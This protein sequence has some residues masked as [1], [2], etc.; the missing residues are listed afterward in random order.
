MKARIKIAALCVAV[1][2]A[3]GCVPGCHSEEEADHPRTATVQNGPSE[4]P[5]APASS[6][7]A[8]SADIQTLQN[9]AKK[10]QQTL[11]EANRAI[12]VLGR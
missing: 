12:G 8:P 1:G 5:S 6:G 9:D 3:L 2:L 10:D 4:A 11:N 7:G